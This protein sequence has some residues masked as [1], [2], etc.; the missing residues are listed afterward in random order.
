[1][2]NV[3]VQAEETQDQFRAIVHLRIS[4][5]CRTSGALRLAFEFSQAQLL[6]NQDL[7]PQIQWRADL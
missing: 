5:R 2:P 4:N 7:Q 6:T 3:D 1:M